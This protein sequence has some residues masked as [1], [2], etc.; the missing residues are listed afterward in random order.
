[1]Y[2]ILLCGHDAI[3]N[4]QALAR[5]GGKGKAVATKVIYCHF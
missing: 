3:I 5:R 1:M 2:D 4:D